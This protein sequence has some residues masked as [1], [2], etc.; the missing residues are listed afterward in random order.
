MG[1]MANRSEIECWLTDMDG[2]LVHENNPIPGAA[3]LLQQWRDEG[4]PYLVL[5]NNS[6]FTPRDLSARLK[7]SG[8]VVPEESIWTSALATADFLKSQKPGGSAFVIGEAG[9]TTALHEAGFIMTETDPDYVVIGETRNYSFEAITKAIRLI[10]DGS[11]FI[12]TNPDAT[13]PS[14][15]GPLPA[16][17][18]VAALITKATG[19]EPY[20]VGKPNPM[21]FRSAMNKI[22]AH[23]ENTGMIG[24][25][26]D[27][28]IVAGIEAGLHTILVLTGIS[29][30]AE[31][32]RYP[33]RP[34]EIL[35][36]VAELVSAEPIESEA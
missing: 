35:T 34:D 26:M 20:V 5:T 14:A 28:D 8:L 27:T 23:S 10:G 16:T 18:A 13:G 12:V 11:R 7:A 2:V 33:F 31:I 6:I 21:M 19:K 25:R 24:D 30:Q 29:D 36:S 4:K 1:R 15:D 22:G 9:I 32:N 3:E 17:G